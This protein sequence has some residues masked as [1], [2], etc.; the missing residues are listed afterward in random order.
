M[1]CRDWAWSG[2]RK[3]Q[4]AAGE[5][6]DGASSPESAVLS[7]ALDADRRYAEAVLWS[8][9]QL[10]LSC[11]QPDFVQSNQGC[12]TATSAAE[13]TSSGC[14]QLSKGLPNSLHRM[15]WDTQGSWQLAVL[16]LCG[17]AWGIATIDLRFLAES[18]LL[19]VH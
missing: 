12:M 14:G 1:V 18:L 8:I 15:F 10:L 9:E 6:V 5:R 4:D 19:L 16:I 2:L 11:P 3:V 17:A 7:L 13:N